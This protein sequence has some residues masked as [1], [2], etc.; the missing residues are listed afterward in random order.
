M[1][2]DYD[3]AFGT[4]YPDLVY[5][6]SACKGAVRR[7][8]LYG[9]K[10]TELIHNTMQLC[11]ARLV[12]SDGSEA[13]SSGAC[14]EC[15][16]ITSGMRGMKHGQ[17]GMRPQL[18]LLDDLETSEIAESPEGCQKLMTILKKDIMPLGG[19]QRLSIL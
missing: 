17:G 3:S 13:P 19:K 4:D 12:E 15:R 1:A 11:F 16:G 7:R 8:Q 14:V 6:F 18:V 10:S 2:S 5:P 9:G